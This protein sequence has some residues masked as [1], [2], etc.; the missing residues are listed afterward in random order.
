MMKR[1]FVFTIFC[2]CIFVAGCGYDTAPSA[3]TGNQAFV[4]VQDDL[5]RNI[6][7]NKKPE[8]IVVTSASFLEPLHEVGGDVVGRPDSSTKMPDYARE[9]TSVGKVYQIDVEKVLACEPD[10]VIINK[11]MNEKLVKTLEDNGVQTMVV[12]VKSYDSVKHMIRMFAKVTGE[13]QKG[14]EL[15]QSMDDRIAS[16]RKKIPAESRRIA[17][18]HCTSQGMSVQL[19]QS[20]AG[21]CASILGWENT[22]A[23][24]V[25]IEHHPDTAPYSLE[26]L[27]EQDPEILFVT[28]MGDAE[29]IKKSMQE[30][31]NESQAM[32]GMSAVRNHRVYY[33]PQDLFLLSPGI[34][35]PDAVRCMA[36]MVYPE[37][38]Q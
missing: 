21:S 24:E 31:I 1:L 19:E 20:I 4:T 22:A 38:F 16:V 3:A 12:D 23:G 28:S 6:V 33:L 2:V 25:P 18:L 27:V 29:N 14:E 32:Q 9:K 26:S 11:G 8:R 17:I 10:L 5:G 34:H 37:A 7:L 13:E 15:V 30:R 36:S 35:Y